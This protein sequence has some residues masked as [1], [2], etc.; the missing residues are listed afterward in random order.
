MISEYVGGTAPKTSAI[1]RDAYG[2][3]LFI[4]EAYSIFTG[5]RPNKN[6]FGKE[7]LATLIA[8]MENHRDDMCV[9]VAGY[10]DEMKVMLTGNSGLESRIPYHIDFPNYSKEELI[11]IFFVMVKSS[12]FKFEK[13]LEDAVAEFFNKIPDSEI[14]TK[15]F[16]NARFVR[17]LF[18]RTWG[19]AAC[20]SRLGEENILLLASDFISAT[21]GKEFRQL[22]EKESRKPIGFGV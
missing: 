5:D 1:C 22:M 20:R 14:N 7:A 4:D 19:K 12:G 8:E 10:Y 15:G 3:V 6:E 16:A 13:A 11:K 2:S 18:E 9:I 21:E 17:N